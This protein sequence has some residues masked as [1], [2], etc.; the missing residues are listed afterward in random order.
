MKKITL[1][2]F[3]LLLFS[4]PALAKD[5]DG[6][7]AVFGPGGDSCQQFLTAQKL[8]GHSAYAYQEWALGY[9]SAFNLI[10][11]NTYNIM[12]TRSMDEGLDWLQDHCRY[13]P[14]TLFVNAIAALTTRLYPERMNMAPNKNTAEKWKRTF[15]SE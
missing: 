8:G 14:S 11:K 13:Q 2:L 10:V 15:G 6:E 7:F 1:L 4:H 9:L 3:T 12:G 5:M